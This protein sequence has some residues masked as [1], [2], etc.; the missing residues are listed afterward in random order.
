MKKFLESIGIIIVAGLIPSLAVILFWVL[1][2]GSF[3]ITDAVYTDEFT[4][5]VAIS[6]MIAFMVVLVRELY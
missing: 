3:N 1:T 2:W 5:S 4:A 6:M